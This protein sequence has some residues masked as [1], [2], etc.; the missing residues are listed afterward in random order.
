MQLCSSQPNQPPTQ[1]PRPR[2]WLAMAAATVTTS[3]GACEA[4]NVFR[5]VSPHRPHAVLVAEN[6]PGFRG[7]FGLGRAVSPRF[8]NDQ[9][10]AFWRMSDRFRIPAGPTVVAAID[11]TVPYDYESMHFT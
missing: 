11:A 7:A 9:P 5:N 2:P 8:I 6:P 3:L 10:T 4:P 1:R